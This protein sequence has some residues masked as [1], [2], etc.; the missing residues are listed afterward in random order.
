MTRI[1]D[2][3]DTSTWRWAWGRERV[4]ARGVGR[5]VI[6]TRSLVKGNKAGEWAFLSK[7]LERVPADPLRDAHP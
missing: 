1:M 6:D 4:G 5:R 7:A 3:M 2:W